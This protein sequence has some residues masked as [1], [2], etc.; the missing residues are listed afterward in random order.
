MQISVEAVRAGSG[1]RGSR[2]E[3]L[4]A[5]LLCLTCTG[6]LIQAW[7]RPVQFLLKRPVDVE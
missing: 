3:T 6:F 1:R 5:R 2:A 7:E 4:Y